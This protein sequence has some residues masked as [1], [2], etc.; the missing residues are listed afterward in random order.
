MYFPQSMIEMNRSGQIVSAVAVTDAGDLAGHCAI[1]FEHDGA[2]IAEMGQAV[3]KPEFRGQGCLRK[4]AEFLIEQAKSIGLTGLYVRAVTSHTY[5]QRVSYRLGFRNCGIMLAYAPS[6]VSFK[7]ID[8]ALNQRETFTVEYQYLR[9]PS[10]QK[11]Y[12]PPHHKSFVAKLYRNLGATPEMREPRPRRQSALKPNHVL[13]AKSTLFEPSGFA[14]LQI[15]ECGRN[16]VAEVR[17]R[18]K[19]LCRKHF[20][21]ITLYL[22]LAD[23]ITYGI[24]SQFEELGFFFSAIFP[25]ESR[26]DTL[27]LQYLNNVAIDYGRIKLHSRIGREVLDYIEK[28]DPNRQ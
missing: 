22:N 8:E 12:A 19:E 2:S 5:S 9:T 14:T 13:V 1:F 10:R 18:L 24:T 17:S 26:A 16:I 20:D 15:K 28:H 21:V 23:P 11:L 4:L 3:V 6:T 27:I 25:G 7:K